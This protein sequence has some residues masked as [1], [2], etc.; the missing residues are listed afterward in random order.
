VQITDTLPDGTSFDGN[1][2]NNFWEK[3]NFSGNPGDTQLTWSVDRLAPGWTV[4]VGFEAA[5]DSALRGVQGL[6]FTNV[7]E[8]TTPPGDLSPDDNTTQV[9]ART[10]PD[11]FVEKWLNKGD[12]YPGEVITYTVRFGNDNVQPWNVGDPLG[13]PSV[14]ITDTLPAGM[15]F[16]SATAPWDPKQTWNPDF[17]SGNTVAWN[18]WPFGSNESHTFDIT[19]R[20]LPSVRG[21]ALLT[22][23]VEIADVVPG[24]KDPYLDNN[25]AEFGVRVGGKAYLPL[26]FR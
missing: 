6:A 11:L 1:W 10:G 7:A 25:K 26:I 20:I 14:L 12:L 18:A 13:G 2:W 17:Q 3:M 16:I 19:A 4:N 22:N 8:I 5:L 21:G 24:D 9:V 15:E 23:T